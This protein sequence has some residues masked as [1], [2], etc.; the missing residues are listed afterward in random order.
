M[1]GYLK[2]VPKQMPTTTFP[3]PPP[4][5]SCGICSRHESKLGTAACRSCPAFKDKHYFPNPLGHENCDILFV[6]DAPLV[7]RLTLVRSDR[8]PEH[9]TFSD[10]AGK[11]V[12]SAVTQ[13]QRDI[14]Y[15]RIECRYTYAVRCAADSATKKMIES[16]HS[17]LLGEIEG[18]ATARAAAG[19]KGPLVIV[20]HGTAALRALGIAAPSENEVMGQVYDTML[21]DLPVKIVASRSMRSIVGAPGKFSSLLADVERA[22]RL[23]INKPVVRLTQEQL[24]VGYVYPKTI[25]EVAKLCEDIINYAAPNCAP[26]EWAISIDTETNTLFPHR[27]GLKLTIVS[28]AWAPGKAC[29]IPLWHAQTPY[30]PEEAWPHVLRVLHCAKKK[31]FFNVKYDIKVFWKKGTDVNRVYWDV[32]LAEH[33]LEED[34]KGQYGLKYL[35]K[36]FLPTHAGYEDQLHNMLVEAQ[37]ERQL[38]SAKKE[39]KELEVAVGVPEVAQK[40]IAE[41]DIRPNFNPTKLA[42]RIAELKEKITIGRTPLHTTID[43]LGL[44]YPVDMS[45]KKTLKAVT[46]IQTRAAELN[47]RLHNGYVATDEELQFQMDAAVFQQDT[48]ADS[49]IEAPP[50]DIDVKFLTAAEVVLQ[51]ASYFKAKAPK[52]DKQKDSGGFEN[53]PLWDAAGKGVQLF[54]AAVDADVTRQLAIQQNTR[55]LTEDNS[56][57]AEQ[58]RTA[59]LMEMLNR[60]GGGSFNVRPLCTIPNPVSNLV[61]TYYMPRSIELASMEYRGIKV[62]RDHIKRAIDKLEHVVLNE[63]NTLYKLAGQEFKTGSGGQIAR[64]LF[65]S[66]EGYIPT[67]KEHARKMAEKYPDRVKFNG[68]RVMYKSNSYTSNGTIQTTEKVLGVLSNTYECEFANSLL[69]LRKASKAKDTFLTNGLILSQYDG[70]LH[71]SYHLSGTATGRLS[72]SDLNM[73]NISGNPMGGIS[74]KDPRYAT[75][76]PEQ[77]EGVS[78]KK[79]FIPD[80]STFILANADARGAEISV[81]AAYSR[82]EELIKALN[83]GLDAHSFFSSKILNP[84]VV[85]NGLTGEDRKRLLDKIGIDDSHA[86]NYSDFVNRDKFAETGETADMRDYG[87]RLKKHRDNVKRVVFGILFGAG[88]RKIAEIVGIEVEQAKA[89]INLLFKMFPSI[90]SFIEHTKWEL[91]TFGMVET[92]FGRKRRFSMKNAPKE[93]ISRAERQ[94]VNFKI[95]SSSSDIVLWVLTEASPVIKSDFGGRML[96]TVHDSLGFQIKK[97]Y[98]SQLPEFMN[99][100]GT[101]RVA[102]LCPWLPVAFKWDI[103]VGPSYGELSSINTYLAGLR[104]ESETDVIS[105]EEILHDLLM[106]GAGENVS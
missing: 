80:D 24:E 4:D 36:Q 51:Y 28:I 34:K 15:S 9:I 76:T 49:Y 67:D 81:F 72:S 7:P 92:Y 102:K 23:A 42:S 65:D 2:D 56:Y 41:T 3:E 57:K 29:A 32:M 52:K 18:I 62:D 33:A 63:T 25:E 95:Q 93:M 39:S 91:R 31:I 6:G 74:K 59:K 73:Q 90:P 85:A 69:L 21:N 89:I 37:G 99:E 66:G 83:D 70:F 58:N 79:M 14:T 78:C 87:K 47:D 103:G 35:V 13:L 64:F 75:A 88:S 20:A 105:E 55:M 77:R 12:M 104:H 100:Y 98:V 106:E 94:A 86:W 30:D 54:Y 46:K 96:L 53:I 48:K 27:D 97:E 38:D 44:T 19:N 10:T 45:T 22:F 8:E 71:T 68:E 26:E 60:N 50:S 43:R 16:C 82:D 101:K 84:D 61:K 40:A 11:I 5:F 1:T 17:H